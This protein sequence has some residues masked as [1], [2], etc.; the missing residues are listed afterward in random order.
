MARI[1]D[2]SVAGAVVF[3]CGTKQPSYFSASACQHGVLDTPFW[4]TGILNKLPFSKE[5]CL[6]KA[7]YF[8][9]TMG[10]SDCLLSGFWPAFS[11]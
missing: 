6:Q 5:K 4:R 7:F 8:F 11:F 2:I 1:K 3:H 9:F 10:I